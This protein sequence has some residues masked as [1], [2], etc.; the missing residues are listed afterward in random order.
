[1]N[2]RS[3]LVP[4][5]SIIPLLSSPS[6]G[7]DGSIEERAVDP[8]SFRPENTAV[9]VDAE[10]VDIAR[11]F[12]DLDPRAREWYQHVMTLSNPWFEGRAP[13]S[14]G[15]ERAADYLEYW[16]RRNGL[17][18]AFPAADDASDWTSYRQPMVLPGGR[19]RISR[20][21]LSIDG[22]ELEAG[23]DFT[24][25]G[26]SGDGV[27]VAPLAFAGYA[28]EEGPEGYTSFDVD[29]GDR[30]FEDRL[31]M[32]LRYEPLDDEGRSR[33][34]TRRF[35]R[36]ASI[37][38][39][40]RAV[41]D[42]GAAGV[43][44]VNP[45]GA[46]FAQDGL[47]DDPSGRFGDGLGIPVIQ[48]APEIADRMLAAAG[49]E[50]Q[51][52][53]EAL[54]RIA[55]EG[56]HGA[57]Q[58]GDVAAIRI[59]TGIDGGARSTSNLGG[60]LR[61]RGDLADEWLVIGAHYDHIG[62]GDFGAMPTN[63]GRLHPGADDDA[64][65]TAAVI[66]LGR[67]LADRYAEA[68]EDADL[69]SI[70]FLGFTAEESGLNGSRHYVEHPTLPADSI[71]AMLNLDMIGRL[72]NDTLAVGGMDSA[73]GLLERIRPD[74]EASGLDIVADPNGRGPS[75]HA[76]FYG[77][78]IPVMYFFTGTHDDY[79]RPGDFGWTVNP[80]GA[81]KVIDLVDAVATRLATDPDRLDFGD[82]RGGGI[83]TRPSRPAGNDRGYASVRLGIRPGMSG[84]EGFGVKVESVSPGTSAEEG[85]ILAGDVIVAWGGEDLVDVMDMVG[86]LRE[87]KPGDVVPM[88]VLRDGAEV[89]L[90]VT[91]KASEQNVQE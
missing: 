63:R 9:V 20:A 64:S 30:P 34:T 37:P 13:G 88:V 89:E 68:D 91:M 80:R 75:D 28:I 72:R 5:L 4:V 83:A 35:S 46:R 22:R 57:I 82:G 69:R 79:H 84:G 29:D 70:L 52:D 60:V 56:S 26:N 49:G 55:D 87:H 71:N 54:R 19:P 81:A 48:V 23:R 73:V 65:G 86:R 17:E 6:S 43:V 66:M 25:L 51:V 74:L 16:Y 58:I 44:L 12:E 36:F 24:V 67:I 47:E 38:D 76:S 85:G 59:E 21:G 40:M 53:L 8:Y 50:E 39:K 27:V 42:R 31:V 33:F 1:M 14:D 45:P 77:A 10:T 61:G 18:P 15:I 11:I 7:Q 41:A 78:G 2:R 3:M 90:D 32:V 62:F